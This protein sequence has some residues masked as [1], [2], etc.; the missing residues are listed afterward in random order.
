MTTA[1]TVGDPVAVEVLTTT[2]GSGR[3]SPASFARWDPDSSSWKTSLELFDTDSPTSSTTLPASGSMRNGVCSP[4][5]PLAP[6][7]VANGSGSWPADGPPTAHHWPTP[8]TQG[9][10]HGYMK[11]KNG[12]TLPTLTGAATAFTRGTPRASDG[13]RG[14]DPVRKNRAAGAPTLKSQA[15]AFPRDPTTLTAGSDGKVLN[16]RFVE[17]LMGLPTGWLTP[18]TSAATASSPKQPATPSTFSTTD[19]TPDKDPA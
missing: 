9:I 5:P 4:R 19:S 13:A 6:P 1:P 7:T 11:Q 15:I 12:T 14:S 10:G 8:V 18:S 3:K 2:A 17:A 16:P